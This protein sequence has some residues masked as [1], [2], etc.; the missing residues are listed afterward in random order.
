MILFLQANAFHR[1]ILLEI[2]VT[3]V[4]ASAA[5]QTTIFPSQIILYVC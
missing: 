1:V 2:Y 4:H 3:S 5:S